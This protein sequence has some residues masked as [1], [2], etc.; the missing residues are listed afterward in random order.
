MVTGKPYNSTVSPCLQ[1]LHISEL[2]SFSKVQRHMPLL[3]VSLVKATACGIIIWDVSNLQIIKCLPR[4]V[5]KLR[6]Q[7]LRIVLKQLFF[8][9]MLLY[10]LSVSWQ[11]LKMA[12]HQAPAYQ[13]TKHLN[14]MVHKNTHLISYMVWYSVS[15]HISPEMF[16]ISCRPIKNVTWYTVP[17]IYQPLDTNGTRHRALFQYS[18]VHGQ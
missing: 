15:L 9:T 4:I 6:P 10:T 8:E 14:D 3:T 7:K 11:I 18:S 12:G 17:L 13:L 1:K 16:G 5:D 2:D